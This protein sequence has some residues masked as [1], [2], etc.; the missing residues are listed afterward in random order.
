MGRSDMTS[1]SP[2]PDAAGRALWARAVATDFAG[3]DDARY[4][5][6]AGFA[7]GV[8][9]DDDRERVAAWLDAD[10]VAAADVAAARRVGSAA[11]PPAAAAVVARAASLV[12]AGAGGEAVVFARRPRR[13]ALPLIANWAGWGSIAAALVVAG[14]LGFAMGS[15]VSSSFAPIAQPNDEGVLHELFDPST[16]FLRNVTEGTQT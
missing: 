10:P 9:D 15:D 12:V 8:L 3:D 14:W 13:R 5:D 1:G 6:L 4:L 11:L 7:D 16:G 2:P